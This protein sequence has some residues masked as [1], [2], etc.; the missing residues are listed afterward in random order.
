MDGVTL[1]EKKTQKVRQIYLNRKVTATLA[2]WLAVHPWREQPDAPLFPN[3][4]TGQ[5]LLVSTISRMVKAWCRAVGLEGH[6]SAHTLRKTFGY[7]HRVVHGTELGVIVR[8][9]NHSSYK[10]TLSY[11]CIEAEQIREVYLKEI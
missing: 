11:L 7:M 8:L 10:Q 3:L 6:Y 2:R 9:F 4:R 5:A 1:R